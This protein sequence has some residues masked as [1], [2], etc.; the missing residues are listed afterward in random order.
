MKLKGENQEMY[1]KCCKLVRLFETHFEGTSDEDGEEEHS[2]LYE[3]LD[4][5]N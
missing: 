2:I 5:T 3:A 1:E 4:E